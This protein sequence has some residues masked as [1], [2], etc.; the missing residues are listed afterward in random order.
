[1]SLYTALAL[2]IAALFAWWVF[3]AV[4]LD[5]L[6]DTLQTVSPSALL[7]VAGIFLVQ[8]A[9]R[10]WRQQLLVQAVLPNTTYRGNLSVLCMSFFCINSFPARLGELVRPAL[11]LEKEDLPLGSGFSVVFMERILDLMM[12]LGVL[13]VILVQL[14]LPSTS[15]SVNGVVVDFAALAQGAAVGVVLP[16]FSLLVFLALAPQKGLGLVQAVIRFA[17]SVLPGRWG[18]QVEAIAD[19]FGQSFL[20]GIAV[21][22]QPARLAKVLLITAVA[23]GGTGFLY[24]QL[25]NG[26]PALAGQ[27]SWSQ[28]M[29]IL[30]ITMLATAIPALPG[31][32]AVYEG[33]VVAAFL[34]LGIGNNPEVE[35][36]AFALVVHWWVYAVQ[37]S[38][39]F[40]YFF[41]EGVS[42]AKLRA[43]T[44][45]SQSA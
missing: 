2:S 38:T 26:F 18:Q 27:I 45:R 29:G 36:L 35:G 31:F 1:L 33:A 14:D 40:Y 28:G 10:A 9:L 37:A 34:L 25:A 8:Q 17:G 22:R 44:R 20:Q 12:A 3:D 13:L 7:W 5:Q 6:G 32:A 42:V 21:V 24:V 23:W 15:V 30:V 39:A 11:L 16:V 19:R 41:R 4:P 43:A